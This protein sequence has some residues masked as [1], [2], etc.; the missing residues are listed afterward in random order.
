MKLE[1]N[2]VFDFEGKRFRVLQADADP[3]QVWCIDID[4][5]KAWPITFRVSHVA[6]LQFVE[7]EENLPHELRADERLAMNKAYALLQGLRADVPF[8]SLVQP[9]LRKAAIR[10]YVEKLK[11]KAEMAKEHGVTSATSTE[12]TLYKY[13]RRFWQRGQKPQALLR[14]YPMGKKPEDETKQRRVVGLTAGRGRPSPRGVSTYQVT[15][16]DQEN[17]RHFIKTYIK[18]LRWKIPRTH[19]EMLSQ[20]YR[21]SEETKALRDEGDY[22]SL[23]QFRH[24]YNTVYGIKTRKKNAGGID[25]YNQNLRSQTGNALVGVYGVGHI[26]EVD[27]SPLECY[28]VLEEDPRCDIGKPTLYLIIDRWSRLIVGYYLGLE[29]PSWSAAAMAFLSMVEDKQELCRKYGVEYDPTDW[30]AHGLFPWE[31]IVDRGSEWTSDNSMRYIEDIGGVLNIMPT[32]RPEMK[33]IVESMHGQLQQRLQT[34]EPSADPDANQRD[35]QRVDY[36]KDA[37]A[38]M[39]LL[40][41][42]VLETIIS[43]NR[44]EQHKFP[45][46]PEMI[47]AEVFP[48]PLNLWTFG[49]GKTGG[50]PKMSEAAVRRALLP[51][52]E[53]KVSQFGIEFQKL[54]YWSK[55]AE[56][57]EW[58]DLGHDKSFPVQVQ[59][60]PRRCDHILVYPPDNRK[61]KPHLAKLSP[62]SAHY[63]GL[64]FADTDEL[65]AMLSKLAL[66][67]KHRNRE[68]HV[69][70]LDAVEPAIQESHAKMKAATK[71]MSKSARKKNAKENRKTERNRE[72]DDRPIIVADSGEKP[73]TPV[74]SVPPKLRVVTAGTEPATEAE[75]HISGGE[76]VPVAAPEKVAPSLADRLAAFKKTFLPPPPAEESP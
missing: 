57:D 20:R 56:D 32:N 59:H 34:S 47:V 63:A 52:G 10:A 65:Q 49:I 17:M 64:P 75:A 38:T 19:L 21:V 33:P 45:M 66:D 68:E 9:S 61:A 51:R 76:P 25:N 43:L 69:R 35:R 72:R 48:T 70:Y 8:L 11:L 67:G 30:P 36:R 58:F 12:P 40:N 15:A 14:D 18:D 1:L 3:N 42:H 55:E 24:F 23:M 2:A 46:T 31:F 44:T 16:N 7:V 29:N 6:L 5:G 54:F 37:H 27:A 22:P 53:A 28:A 50:L 4:D 13:L 73:P 39:K 41:K 71:G 60:D 26:F 74:R 62:R